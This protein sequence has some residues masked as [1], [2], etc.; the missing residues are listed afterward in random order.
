MKEPNE[1]GQA[2]NIYSIFLIRFIDFYAK[3][4]GPSTGIGRSFSPFSSHT[5]QINMRDPKTSEQELRTRLKAQSFKLTGMKLPVAMA[6]ITDFYK[7][8]RDFDV[9][10]EEG[11]G[12]AAYKDVTDHGRGTRVEIGLTRLFRFAPKDEN[13][14]LW[15]GARLKLRLCYKWDRDVIRLVMPEPTWSFDCWSLTGL[16]QFKES[17]EKT[18]GYAVLI[19]KI[20]SEVHVVLEDAFY[21]RNAYRAKP[22][23][24]Q[25]WWGN[26]DVV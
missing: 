1:A 10:A 9:I 17:V 22:E 23:M 13:D 2:K 3:T 11:D 26:V 16:A 25:M 15:P 18:D 6:V 21:R 7:E 19:D 12:L 5:M 4:G 24:K 8:V 20:P 14:M